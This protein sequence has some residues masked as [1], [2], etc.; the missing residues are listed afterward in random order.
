MAI[1]QST[2]S[3]FIESIVEA[4]NYVFLNTEYEPGK[5]VGDLS[6][7]IMQPLDTRES[8]LKDYIDLLSSFIYNIIKFSVFKCS[9]KEN[10]FKKFYRFS[11]GDKSVMQW[12]KFL[13]LVHVGHS[14]VGV[15]KEILYQYILDKFPS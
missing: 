2:Q 11:V 3:L 9:D 12:I 4:A 10:V 6:R 7:E 5:N 1:K 8:N 14:S 15:V 13:E